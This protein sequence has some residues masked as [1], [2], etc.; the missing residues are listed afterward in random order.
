[1]G[2]FP[3]GIDLAALLNEDQQ[4]IEM[5]RRRQA[6]VW[7]GDKPDAWPIIFTAP[8]SESQEALPNPNYE[9]AFYDDDL[10]LASQLRL[11]C[12]VNNSRSDA[13]PSIRANLGTGITLSCVGLKQLVFPDKMPWLKE[14]MS[15]EQISR[16]EPDDIKIQGDFGRGLDCMRFFKDTLQN[17]L[18]VY[19][20]DTQGP[21]DL[22]HL[23]AGDDLFY[24][25]YD[26]PPYVHHLME[27]VVELG[28]RTH[29]WMK[30]ATGEVMDRCHHGNSLYSENFG[31]RICEDTSAIIGPD[32]VAEFSIPY[33]QKLARAFGGAYVHYCGRSDHL[34]QA[35][36]EAPDIKG[37]NFGFIPGKDDMHNYDEEMEKCLQYGTVYTG[38][39]PRMKGE[40]GKAFLERM[41]RWAS[42]GV[43]IPH[44]NAAVAK[45][46]YRELGKGEVLADTG[47]SDAEKFENIEDALDFWYGLN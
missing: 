27:F 17:G 12:A 1:M 18:P 16:L 30:E 23:L 9:E 41:H 42:Q 39:W 14:H 21:L 47:H 13:V 43:L 44:G 31:I 35:L 3:H 4:R 22:A 36:L 28:L 26:D 20:M 33:D 29:R 5:A 11:A 45:P 25:M 46:M 34:T 10:M 24:A 8:L 2:N 37:I 15:R 32:A 6:A 19:C 38:P 7:Q 40:S